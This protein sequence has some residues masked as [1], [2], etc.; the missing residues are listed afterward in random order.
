VHAGIHPR[1]EKL[2]LSFDR[3]DIAST[4]SWVRYLSK[5]YS[6]VHAGEEKPGDTYWA[7]LYD[8]RFGVVYYGHQPY[9]ID[10]PKLIKDSVG[11]DLGCCYGGKLCAAIVKEDVVEFVTVDAKKKYKNMHGESYE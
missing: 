4:V 5:N 6:P 1:L 7:E 2:K 11:L 3:N 10:S 8:G 9:M